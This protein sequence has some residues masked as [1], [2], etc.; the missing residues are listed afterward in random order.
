M[1]KNLP[2]NVGDSGSI[3]CRGTKIS[4]ATEQL[5]LCA[6]ATD[7]GHAGAHELKLESP[8]VTRKDPVGLSEDPTYCN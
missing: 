8:W 5:S 2:C 1:G 3:P 6:T 4:H 7:P